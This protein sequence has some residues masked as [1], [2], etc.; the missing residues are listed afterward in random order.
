MFY[1]I[2]KNV[3][4]NAWKIL[5]CTLS[6]N[7]VNIE[8][9]HVWLFKNRKNLQIIHMESNRPNLTTCQTNPI[10]CWSRT[11]VPNSSV[12]RNPSPRLTPDRY[13][14]RPFS[15][16]GH[17]FH[18]YPPLTVIMNNCQSV[19]LPTPTAQRL[20]LIR[21]WKMVGIQ[22]SLHIVIHLHDW[23]DSPLPSGWV[24]SFDHWCHSRGGSPSRG[25]IFFVGVICPRPGTE[26]SV[27]DRTTAVWRVSDL[28]GNGV[29]WCWGEK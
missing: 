29:K 6:I 25:C 8:Y 18:N 24:T 16:A 7:R 28:L 1:R 22:I 21:A 2:A 9:F 13:H 12:A 17:T 19:I 14:T 3:L 23:V 15:S 20:P 5:A 10:T 11:T 27:D 4:F 26:D